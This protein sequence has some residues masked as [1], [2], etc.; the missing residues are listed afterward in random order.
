M[1]CSRCTACCRVLAVSLSEKEY[2]SGKYRLMF[3]HKPGNFEEAELCGSNL[4]AQKKDKSCFYL[5]ENGCKIHKDRPQCCRKFF[6]KS[7]SKKLAKPIK[8]VKEYK[9]K[10]KGK[11]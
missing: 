4:I 10:L 3:P 8:I 5:E 2:K 7:K 9:S 1:K 11:D 6:C